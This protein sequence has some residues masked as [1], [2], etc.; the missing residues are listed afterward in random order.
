MG[1]L[2][3]YISSVNF[4]SLSVCERWSPDMFDDWGK[5]ESKGTRHIS[6]VSTKNSTSP[7]V[8]QIS[9]IAPGGSSRA[10]KSRAIR[11]AAAI[12]DA[13]MASVIGLA[14]T[15]KKSKRNTRGNKKPPPRKGKKSVQKGGTSE[16]VTISK[17]R[18]KIRFASGKT[19]SVSATQVVRRIP[20]S[21]IFKAVASIQKRRG[22]K[23]KRG[24]K[25]KGSKRKH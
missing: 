20:V 5:Y 14:K 22:G 21:N 3:V 7:P 23:P 6:I 1:V 11:E 18:V 24:G 17:G 4:S 10:E 16:K 19:R 9:V 12:A 25:R 13:Q 8:G 15:S 2:F